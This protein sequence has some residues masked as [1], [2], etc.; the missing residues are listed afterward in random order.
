MRVNHRSAD[1][2]VAEEFLNRSDVIP[3][4][5]QMGCER[6]T[7][8]SGRLNTPPLNQDSLNSYGKTHL[9]CEQKKT[10]VALTP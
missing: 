4:F 2:A 10:I 3:V 1:V 5:K 8:S 6:V 9:R 7:Q